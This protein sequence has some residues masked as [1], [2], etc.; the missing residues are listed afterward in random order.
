MADIIIYGAYGYTGE[1]IVKEALQRGLA[2]LLS[3][4]DAQKLEAVAKRFGLP[5]KT[6]NL[7]STAELDSLLAGAK[8]VIHAAGPFLHTARPM[9]EACIRNGVHYTDITGEIA[10][11]QMAHSLDAKA[12]EKG[13]ML[14]SG[15]GF[16]IVPSDCLAAHLKSRMPDAESLVMAFHSGGKASRGTSLT[17]VEGMGMGGAIREN[18][19]LKAV[20][21]AFDIQRFDFGEKNLTAVTIPWGDVFT[22]YFSTG[23]PNT[24]VY[25]SMPEKMAKGLRWGRWFG[26]LTRSEWFKDRL[27]NKIKAGIP[28][29]TDAERA[30]GRMDL[31]GFVTNAKGEKVTSSIRTPEGYTLTALTAVHI[32]NE[33]A[34]GN[35]RAGFQ[36]P[37][38]VYGKDL[39]TKFSEKGF[40]DRD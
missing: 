20:P 18:G 32:A 16:D 10:V 35:L 4:R 25:M 36:T 2:P 23:I 40:E 27:R 8:V 19:K 37:S 14:M 24:R 13:V 21:D 26:W 15:T 31:T 39:V 12:R 38:M 22:A 33:V 9:M 17:V 7:S 11:F 1:L 3:G 30:K 5:F 34:Q 28:G 6:C 29:P